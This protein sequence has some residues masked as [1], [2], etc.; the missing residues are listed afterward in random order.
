MSLD[1]QVILSEKMDGAFAYVCH[2]VRQSLGVC[3][4]WV[5]CLS[6]SF[7]IVK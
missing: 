3:G 2:F 5:V 4:S 7:M 1:T 6:T